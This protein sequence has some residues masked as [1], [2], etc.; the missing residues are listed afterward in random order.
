[1]SPDTLEAPQ[2]APLQ[3]GRDDGIGRLARRTQR[4][5]AGRRVLVV[6]LVA[7]AVGIGVAA[8]SIAASIAESDRVVEVEDRFGP[9]AG[10]LFVI[11]EDRFAVEPP[12]SLTDAQQ[13]WLDAH[14]YT[15]PEL[16]DG[17]DFEPAA[18][19]PLD[20]VLA[21]VAAELPPDDLLVFRTSGMFQFFRDE[22]LLVTDLDTN[23]PLAAGTFVVDGPARRLEGEEALLSPSLLADLDAGVG[24]R[25]ELPG[26][27]SVEVVGTAT[28]A[29]TRSQELAVVAPGR[30]VPGG[31][32]EQVVRVADVEDAALLG[33]RLKTAVAETLG[34]SAPQQGQP[35]IGMAYNLE[36]RADFLRFQEDPTT[37][38]ALVGGVSSGLA[39]T[40]AAMVAACAF[41]VGVRR[42][43]RQ[44]GML[45]AVGA[46]PA[47]LRRLL[48]REGLLIGLGGALLGAAVGGVLVWLGNPLVEHFVDRELPFAL[49]V[50]GVALPIVLGAL[51]A[52]L[53]SVWPARTAARVPTVTALAGRVPLGRVPTWLPLAGV[54]A[55][56]AGLLLLGDLLLPSGGTS[57]GLD[58][59]QL[60]AATL[61][62][63]LGTAAVGVPLV[64]LG[65]RLADRLPLLPRLALRDAARQRSRSGAAIAALVP[66]L[67]LPVAGLTLWNSDGGFPQPDH[68]SAVEYRQPP[69][70]ARVV[71][72][73][74]WIEGRTPPPSEELVD[75]VA[76]LLPGARPAADVVELGLPE[77]SGPLH[78]GTPG[79]GL[80]DGQG[81]DIGPASLATPE[82]LAALDLPADAVPT[83]GVLLLDG[84]SWA[85]PPS[86][87]ALVDLIAPP[88]PGQ[89]D[90][91]RI[92]GVPATVQEFTGGGAAPAV[93]VDPALADRAGLVE[94]GRGRLLELSRPPTE[95]ERLAV[96]EFARGG[97]GPP[98]A[99]SVDMAASPVFWA[100]PLGVLLIAAAVACAVVL[101]VSAVAGMTTA[102]AATESDGDL[103][104]AV[105]LGAPPALRRRFHGVQA[106]WHVQVAALL[107]TTLGLALTVAVVLGNTRGLLAGPD[108][109][110]TV[111]A[112][113][114]VPWLALTAW[115]LVV[116]VL[117]G[118]LIAGLMRSSPVT[119]PRRRMA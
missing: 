58:A 23:H 92:D 90:G 74:P 26:V 73:G 25:L 35:P 82:L 76:A 29:A 61:L 2:L 24:D 86:D 108:L 85:R 30:D 14:R 94:V 21:G 1:M 69:P 81:G 8:A 20:E 87:T 116:P 99:G 67:A 31:L 84:A 39:T 80:F 100:T 22:T 59:L 38:A 119:A 78:A 118:L 48:R 16:P 13:A 101:T 43:I 11:D 71:V 79:S 41:A 3:R 113:V 65:G 77:A 27:G 51:G 50:V 68:G 115:V 83:A 12:A 89:L 17:R 91:R 53:A 47:Q 9:A 7:L 110:A 66:V 117:V 95:A 70:A 10:A 42:R 114:D 98:L 55:A 112:A 104:K 62:A 52:V 54:A 57:P 37:V 34:G 33:R 103:R 49:P 56:L 60:L 109:L 63:T 107:G 102:L 106:W 5:Q 36:A 28:R 6:A 64:A 15:G 45:G 32:P 72:R 96:Q 4:G 44:V 19:L 46:D 105:A 88:G 111:R 18:P 40:L 97:S 93:L 75:Q